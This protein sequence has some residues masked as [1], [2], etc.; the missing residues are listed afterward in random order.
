MDKREIM[1][2]IS[3]LRPEERLEYKVSDAFGF[4]RLDV[5][6]NK[7]HPG[8]YMIWNEDNRG[9]IANLVKH[10]TLENAVYWVARNMISDQPRVLRWK[11][12][13]PGDTRP[14]KKRGFPFTETLI[15][16]DDYESP[17]VDINTKGEKMLN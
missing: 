8:Y 13:F 14:K 10:S 1:R 15:E 4:D 5:Q 7:E 3:E 9:E 6:K 17:Y 16:D 11:E 2:R 12:I